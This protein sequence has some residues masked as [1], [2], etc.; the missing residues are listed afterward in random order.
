MHIT[1]ASGAGTTTLGRALATAWS[2]PHADT[3]DYFW[4]PTAPPYT[5]KRAASGR[6]RLMEELFLPRDA[7]V[8]SGSLVGWGDQLVDRFDAVVFLSV[9]QAVRIDRLHRRE[10]ARY[11]ADIE[12]GG[13]SERSYREFIEWASGYE[14][15][16]FDGRSRV[17]HEA[18]L[19][20]LPCPVLRLDSARPT[21]ELV[22]A[23]L[24]A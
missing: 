17:E 13:A 3:D 6:L 16:D 12:A 9:D 8:L 18:W 11:G 20:S 7:W 24:D 15:P 10:R 21:D 22:A 5:T 4:V 23:I 2:V 14:D 1:G 19:D